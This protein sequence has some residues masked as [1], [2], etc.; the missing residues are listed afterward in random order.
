[1]FRPEV[2]PGEHVYGF[3]Q[4]H[5][6]VNLPYDATSNINIIQFTTA[7]T[8]V[9]GV[10]LYF[11]GNRKNISWYA[12]FAP[13][14]TSHGYEVWMMDYPGYGKSTGELTEQRL[15]DWALVTYK[16]ARV[17][18]SPDS[19]I[20]YG[21]SMGSGFAAQLAAVR[22]CRW[23]VMETPYYSFPSIVSQ[24]API[25]P[26][27]RMIKFKVPTNQ[28][29]QKVTAPVTIFHGTDD[30]VIRYSNASRLKPYL[31]PQDEF[32][33]IPHGSHNDLTESEIYLKKLASILA[34]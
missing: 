30:G 29:L 28:Y 11:H 5:K 23:L 12:K 32:V 9:K 1:M 34:H 10:V 17:R 7:D 26:V 25:Y 4:P 15:Y 24:Y 8:A 3:A 6:E 14:F 33:T 22:D 2:L 19:I 20:I 18:F 27:N 13:L 21:K 16:L 31:K